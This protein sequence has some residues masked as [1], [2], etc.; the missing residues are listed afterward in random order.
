MK[1]YK[2]EIKQVVK[3]ELVSEI[4]DFCDKDLKNVKASSLS[5]EVE[6]T[7]NLEHYGNSP[8]IDIDVNLRYSNGYPE[9]NYS[10]TYSLDICPT[11]FKKEILDKA[12]RYKTESSKF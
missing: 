5:K 2:E 7:F 3:Q 4:C 6:T 10:Y 1:T 9:C 11:C 12:K 8:Y